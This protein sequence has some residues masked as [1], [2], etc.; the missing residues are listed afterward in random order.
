MQRYLI[1]IRSLTDPG[2]KG[3]EAHVRFGATQTFKGIPAGQVEIEV[4]R[5]AGG[6]KFEVFRTVPASV[7]TGQ[8]IRFDQP[9]E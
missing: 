6:A 4:L 7:V 9:V 5:P 8:T 2:W 3:T 1:R